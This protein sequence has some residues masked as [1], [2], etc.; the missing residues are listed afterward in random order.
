MQAVVGQ[1]IAS[2]PTIPESFWRSIKHLNHFRL[3]LAGFLSVA[4]LLSE[5]FLQQH[6]FIDAT[7]RGEGENPFTTVLEKL[8]LLE[9]GRASCRERVSFL[10]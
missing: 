10:V 6:P 5:Q 1:A 2:Q 8:A 4:G 7:V 9:I 3:F